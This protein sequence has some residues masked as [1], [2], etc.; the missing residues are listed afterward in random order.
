[1]VEPPDL[2][3]AEPLNISTRYN[4]SGSN[5]LR[6]NVCMVPAVF[7]AGSEAWD[8]SPEKCFIVKLYLDTFLIYL[9]AFCRFILYITTVPCY[10]TYLQYYLFKPLYRTYCISQ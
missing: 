6:I 5:L 4:V 7:D 8:S 9:K 3:D 10:K 1:M 2:D